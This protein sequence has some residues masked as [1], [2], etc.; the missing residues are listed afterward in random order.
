MRLFRRGQRV[1]FRFGNATLLSVKN[2]EL[3]AIASRDQ[4]FVVHG[5][6]RI[7]CSRV[8]G[9]KRGHHGST[10][11]IRE[12]QHP[13]LLSLRTEYAYEEKPPFNFL[14]RT[15]R[16]GFVLYNYRS[17]PIEWSGWW[18]EPV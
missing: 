18:L 6:A 17:S 15:R 12:A 1:Q 7:P 4:V 5:T 10:C 9:C 2:L 13:Q 14:V 11:A 8:C 16:P 3:G